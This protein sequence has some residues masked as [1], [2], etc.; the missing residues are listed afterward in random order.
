MIILNPNQASQTL[1]ATPFQAKK[2]YSTTI[3]HYLFMVESLQTD[4]KYYFIGNVQQDNARYTEISIST[5][6]DAATS[7]NILVTE[8]GQYSYIIYGQT[9]NT[10][11]DPANA[12]VVGELERGLMTFTG[13][14]AWSMP[15]ID[16]P[17]N[18][19]YYE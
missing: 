19:V 5:N 17:D 10:N 18:V 4:K 1:Y 12:V 11:L 6:A 8:S 9:N 3:T 13:E 7:G 2:D 14:D 16:I 15:S